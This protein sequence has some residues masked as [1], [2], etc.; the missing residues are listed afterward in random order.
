[1]K[2]VQDFDAWALKMYEE[3]NAI[4]RTNPSRWCISVYS[5]NNSVTL[6][7]MDL[8][9]KKTGFA[10]VPEEKYDRIIGIGV[11]YARLREYEVPKERRLLQLSTLKNQQYFT[12][13]DEEYMFVGLS[14]PFLAVCVNKNNELKML[15]AFER[16]FLD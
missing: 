14:S 9:K 2:F 11:A 1:M 16:V 3:Y 15:S 7:L 5:E 6:G 13:D 12:L 10:K 8:K 4:R